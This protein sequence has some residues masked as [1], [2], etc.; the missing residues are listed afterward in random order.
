MPVPKELFLSHSDKDREFAGH[1][2]EIL[3]RHGVPYWYSRRNLRGGQQ[4]HDEI[5]A[6]LDRC[7]WFLVVLSPASVQS[8]WVK[9]ELLFALNDERYEGRILPVLHQACEYRQLS[10]TLAQDQFVDFTESFETGCR[11]LLSSWAL[12]YKPGPAG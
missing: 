3:D 6:A 1:L 10:W 5:G 11:D 4:W 12:G 7:D 8:R 2:A 9:R